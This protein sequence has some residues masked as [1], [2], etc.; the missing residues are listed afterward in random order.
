MD[1]RWPTVQRTVQ[2]GAA[3]AMARVDTWRRQVNTAVAPHAHR[4]FIGTPSRCQH[5]YSTLSPSPFHSPSPSPSLHLS[6]CPPPPPTPSAHL[7]HPSPSTFPSSPTHPT[8]SRSVLLCVATRVPTLRSCPSELQLLKHHLPPSP[9]PPPPLTFSSS[10]DPLPLIRSASHR[11]NRRTGQ[12]SLPS[13]DAVI[14]PHLPCML[15]PLN[16]PPPPPP[17]PRASLKPT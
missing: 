5:H 11:L 1:R 16:C 2:T 3:R 17:L 15:V 7:S 9:P 6:L 12:A 8:H 14:C 4:S 13:Q 10:V